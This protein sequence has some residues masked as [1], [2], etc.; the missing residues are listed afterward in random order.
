MRNNTKQIIKDNHYDLQ[1]K[2]SL[3]FSLLLLNHKIFIA[4][5]CFMLTN[6]YK[7]IMDP[8]QNPLRNLSKIV[9]FQ[10]MC[11]LSMTWSVVF[12]LSA[13]ILYLYGPT[14]LVHVLIIAACLYTS[15]VFRLANFKTSSVQKT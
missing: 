14:V 11:L 9:K 15:E 2:Q 10:I 1:N 12:C 3:D 7:L 6:F 4:N 8:E 5:R 13:G